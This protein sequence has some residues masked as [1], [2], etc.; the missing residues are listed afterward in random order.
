MNYGHSIGHALEAITNFAFP[1]GMAVSIGICIENLLASKY[2]KLDKDISKRIEIIAKKIIDKKAINS[3]K[4]IKEKNFIEIL[5]SDKKTIGSTLKLSVPNNY[6]SM[7]FEN[8]LLDSKVDKKISI[9]INE[10]F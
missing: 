7:S 3:I 5:K 9:A 6:G 10:V 2:F 4:I 8:F 1:H